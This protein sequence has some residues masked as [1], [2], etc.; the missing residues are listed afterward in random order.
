MGKYS[1]LRTKLPAF[2][3]KPEYQELVD[4]AKLYLLGTL[5]GEGANIQRLAAL[6]AN[7]KAKKDALYS[8]YGSKETTDAEYEINIHLN[9]LSQ[10]LVDN[11]LDAGIKKVEL[12]SG[13]VVRLDDKVI[14]VVED[15]ELAIKHFMETMPEVLTF[16]FKGVTGK[17]VKKLIEWAEKQKL[18]IEVGIH[19]GTLKKM[20]KDNA[21]EGKPNFP[22]VKPFFLSSA[23]LSNGSDDL[24]SP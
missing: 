24:P 19:D 23:K 15:K 9:A 18:G 6:F 4:N 20:A 8:Q 21:V 22:G 2:E 16:N 10:L 11:F 1:N 12:D 13:A 14:P 7:Y 5:N 3:E 17:Q